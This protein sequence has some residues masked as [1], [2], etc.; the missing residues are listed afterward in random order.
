MR[1]HQV[2]VKKLPTEQVPPEEFAAFTQHLQMLAFAAKPCSRLCRLLGYVAVNGAIC[3]VMPL[4]QLSLQQVLTT[5][6]GEEAWPGSLEAVV[7]D[8]A[9]QSLPGIAHVG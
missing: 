6:Q 3:Q 2:A 8:M 4:Y 7:L 9:T 5:C 1:M